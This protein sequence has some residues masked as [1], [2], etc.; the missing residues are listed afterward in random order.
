M[1]N[2]D[3]TRRVL[4]Q[5]VQ[6]VRDLAKG[7]TVAAKIRADEI[8]ALLAPQ[9][10]RDARSRAAAA[11]VDAMP[12]AE[13][14]PNAILPEPVTAAAVARLRDLP[15]MLEDWSAVYLHEDGRLTTGLWMHSKI[16]M[17]QVIGHFCRRPGEEITYHPAQAL[18]D[19]A[20]LRGY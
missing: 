11:A 13:R 3:K 20:P 17:H 15:P 12:T 18:D 8:E 19:L 14:Y 5:L 1:M 9:D 16:D 10:R 2:E 7:R 4:E 6:A